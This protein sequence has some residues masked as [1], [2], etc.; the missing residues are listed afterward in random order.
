MHGAGDVHI[1]WSDGG[2]GEMGGEM[3]MGEMRGERW[4]GIGGDGGGGNG[5]RERER[6]GELTRDEKKGRWKVGGLQV[7]RTTRTLS[8][9]QGVGL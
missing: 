1:A 9:R 7:P 6:Q 8:R 3:G 5:E 4:E 2:G